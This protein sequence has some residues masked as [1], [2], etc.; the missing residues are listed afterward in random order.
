MSHRIELTTED[1]AILERAAHSHA[2]VLRRAAQILA[3]LSSGPLGLQLEADRLSHATSLVQLHA[4]G[5]CDCL[6][7][8]G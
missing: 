4:N 3:S 2:A 5:Q 8:N 1:A 6:K 7:A